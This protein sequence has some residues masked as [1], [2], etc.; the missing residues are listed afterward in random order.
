M[1][2]ISVFARLL[3]LLLEQ[4]LKAGEQQGLTREETLQALRHSEELADTLDAAEWAELAR[5]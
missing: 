4:A 1:D 3:A 2:L 5:G